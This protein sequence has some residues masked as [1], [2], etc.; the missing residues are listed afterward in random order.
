M[1]QS[2]EEVLDKHEAELMKIENVTGVGISEI[3]GEQV[4]V[5]YVTKL[6]PE[7]EQKIPK[8]IEGWKV[9]IEEVG[10]VKAY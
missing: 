8:E 5:V 9:V 3:D 10:E 6:T 2:I 1:R 7:I 4:I